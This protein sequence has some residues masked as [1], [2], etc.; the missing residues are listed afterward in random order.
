MFRKRYIRKVFKRNGINDITSAPYHPA[1]NGIVE[2][3]FQTIKE[4]IIHCIAEGTLKLNLLG[5]YS[6]IGKQNTQHSFRTS[7]E[8]Y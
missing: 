6:L 7:Q 4:G 2:R 3:A 5:F 1:S 8:E